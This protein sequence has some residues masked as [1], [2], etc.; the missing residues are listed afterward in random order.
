MR[1]IIDARPMAEPI[2]GGVG[3]VALELADSFASANPDVEIICATTGSVTTEL[4]AR[5]TDKPNVKQIHLKMPNK[6]W[7]LA[8]MLGWVSF[9]AAAEKRSGRADAFFLPN[10]GFVG[11]LPKHIPSVLL[12]HDLS[13]LIEPRWFTLKQRLWHRAVKAE[14]L[15]R[16]ATRLLAVSETTKRDAVRLLDIPAE[17]IDVVPLGSTLKNVSSDPSTKHPAP[18]SPTRYVLALGLGDPRKNAATAIEAVNTL[19]RET[20][21]EDVGL[22]MVG[23]N[24]D[25]V[26][27]GVKGPY[28]GL[29]TPLRSAQDDDLSWIRFESHPSDAELTTLYSGASAFLY[30]SWYEGYGLPLHEAAF[31]GMP[32]IASTAGALP[33][34]APPGTLFANPAKPHH[35]V[36]ALKVAL[37]RQATIKPPPAKNWN[38]AARILYSSLVK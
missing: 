38:E 26:L 20:G 33:E 25:V 8:S 12:L 21:F 7:S 22:V 13:F 36:G 29:S 32:C 34:T 31:F 6:L 9:C 14:R 19:R 10:L 30:P 23:G 37:S 11:R 2:R 1:V 35:W 27:N 24:H 5:L 17:K 4:P 15:I 28:K 3:R 18:S 16:G